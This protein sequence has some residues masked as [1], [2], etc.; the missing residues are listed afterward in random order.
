MCNY[1][2]L[3]LSHTVITGKD[4]CKRDLALFHESSDPCRQS[5]DNALLSFPLLHV[6][7]YKPI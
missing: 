2:L 6:A 1:R 4:T 3:N 7:A 5:S